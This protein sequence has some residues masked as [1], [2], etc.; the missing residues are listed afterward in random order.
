[1]KKEKKTVITATLKKRIKPEVKVLIRENKALFRAIEDRWDKSSTS[2]YGW[3]SRDTGKILHPGTL[4]IIE[5]YLGID[6]NDFLE[7][8]NK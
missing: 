7:T 1:M 6:R 2:I 5:N 8:V 4:E 3:I